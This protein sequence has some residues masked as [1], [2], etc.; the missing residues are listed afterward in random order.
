MNQTYFILLI[1]FVAFLKDEI[2]LMIILK[3]ITE[4]K[5]ILLIT[6]ALFSFFIVFLQSDYINRDGI[7]YLT[8]AKYMLEG[9][10]YHVQKTYN[11]GFFSFLI[12]KVHEISS[13]S[14]QNSAHLINYLLFLISYIFFTKIISQISNNKIPYIF[15]FIVIITFVPIMDKYLGMVLRDHGQWAGIMMGIFGYLKWKKTNKFYDI[16]IWHMGFI[17]AFLFR[18]E[19]ILFF[20][21][22][23]IL[24]NYNFLKKNYLTIILTLIIISLMVIL[25]FV[26]REYNYYFYTKINETFVKIQESIINFFIPLQIETNDRFLK[27][28]LNEFGLSFKYLLFIYIFFYKLFFSFG[29]F[30]IILAYFGCKNKLINKETIKFLS[31]VM[32]ILSLPVFINLLAT[33]VLTNRYFVP[34]WYVL[35]IFVV[36]GLHYLWFLKFKFLKLCRFIIIIIFFTSF[37]FILF[38]SKNVDIDRSLSEWLLENQITLD[39]IYFDDR[40]VAFYSGKFP[41]ELVDID[42]GLSDI[43][44]KYFVIHERN[45]NKFDSALDFLPFKY[46]PSINN[47][48]LIIYKRIN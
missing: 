32:I 10:Q 14:L 21:L 37:L 29:I 24:H 28:L 35:N 46:F 9:S 43:K 8:Q 30:H 20:F 11:W 1:L 4:S 12:A 33:N 3:K 40:R 31:L 38:D 18:F 22:I 23:P 48:K 47:P 39:Y 44:F 25:L 36:F 27:I 45:F 5:L 34:V 17:I 19:S 2:V 41:Y 42:E 7:L 6:L 16:I 26:F 15:S 13:L